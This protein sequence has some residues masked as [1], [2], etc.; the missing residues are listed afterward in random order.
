MRPGRQRDRRRTAP[1]RSSWSRSFRRCSSRSWSRRSWSRPATRSGRRGSP[2]G[3][4]RARRWSGADAG[5]AARDGRCRP[6]L[7][8]GAAVREVEGERRRGLG[9]GAGAA[10]AARPAGAR[11]SGRR[12]R[13]G[14]AVAERARPGLGRAR[15]RRCRLLLLA[16]LV[17]LQLLAAGY[18]LTLADGA[19]EAGA[20]ALARAA[21]PAGAPAQRCRAGRAT[22]SMSRSRAGRV[23]VRLRP[24]SPFAAVAERLAVD[25]RPFAR[26]ERHDRRSPRSAPSEAGP[27]PAGRD[28]RGRRRSPAARGARLRR[29]EPVWPPGRPRRPAAL[30]LVASPRRG[31]GS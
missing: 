28:D 10:P 20:L 2:R 19:A 7:R 22:G 26:R 21:A 4:A 18:A 12:P 25:S 8:A 23:T 13:W 30:D 29:V 5:G 24:P 15:R 27:E 11:G 6:A 17:A 14:P 1:P 3:P 16:G 9:A 31:L